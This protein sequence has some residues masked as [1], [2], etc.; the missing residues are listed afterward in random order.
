LSLS[1]EH[2]CAACGASIAIRGARAFLPLPCPRCGETFRARTEIGGYRLGEVLACS[3]LGVIFRATDQ[4]SAELAVKVIQPPFAAEVV[5]VEYF[6]SEV[7]AIARLNHPHCVRVFATG[8]D[9]GLAWIAM[10]WLTHGSLADRL[11]TRGKLREAEVLAI[12]LQTAGAL[13]AAHAA[14]HGHHD[15]GPENLVFADPRTV[16]VTDFGQAALYRISGNNLGTMWGRAAYVAPERMRGE[17]EEAHSDIYG[18]GVV[19]FQAL[20][21]VLPQGGEPNPLA[22]LE[23]IESVEVRVENFVSGLHEKT[24]LLINRMLAAEP[25]QRFQQW[26]EVVA[27]LAQAGG[28]VARR[29]ASGSPDRSA[30]R[31]APAPPKAVRRRTPATLVWLLGALGFTVGLSVLSAVII[32][33]RQAS[34]ARPIRTARLVASP[35]PVA[36]PLAPPV[37][38]PV[39]TPFPTTPKP[40]PRPTG[41]PRPA[42]TPRAA[43]TPSPAKS[44]RVEKNEKGDRPRPQ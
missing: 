44:K 21:G 30:K 42:A 7:W 38:T 26:S 12:G 25:A 31:S 17:P 8:V 27:Q 22:T 35:P 11:A 10:E 15:V 41:T 2:T 24:V 19:L 18:L 40:T 14:G 43:A 9:H 32:S 29:D 36:T 16:K 3:G 6:V 37:V 33:K 4:G 23:Q 20:T 28:I 1:L 34:G 39:A 13:E 5:D